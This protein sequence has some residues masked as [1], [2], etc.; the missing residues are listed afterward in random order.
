MTWTY[1]G[2]PSMS[3]KDEVRFSTGDTNPKSPMLQDEEIGFLLAQSNNDPAAASVR[4]CESIIA[5]LGRLCDQTV[6]SVSKAYSQM[7]AGYLDTLSILR[8]RAASTTYAS[9]IVGG[10]S[11]MQVRMAN[12]NPDRIRPQFTTRMMREP[13]LAPNLPTVL[14]SDFDGAPDLERG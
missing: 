13:G 7:R 10:I 5:A 11:R 9:P 4:A 6:G 8:T 2:D 14:D 12:R 3:K 1:S